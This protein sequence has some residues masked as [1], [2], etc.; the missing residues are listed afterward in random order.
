MERRFDKP[1]RFGGKGDNTSSSSGGSRFYRITILVMTRASSSKFDPFAL[2][3]TDPILQHR[4]NFM[5]DLI[6][7][8]VALPLLTF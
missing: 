3:C 2:F 8:G 4:R 6:L 5:S 7:G 1:S